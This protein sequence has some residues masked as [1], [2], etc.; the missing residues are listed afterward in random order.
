MVE[1]HIS[2]LI[3][4]RPYYWP[5]EPPFYSPVLPNELTNSDLM[6]DVVVSHS[7]PPFCEPIGKIG[8]ESWLARDNALWYDIQC[9]RNTLEQIY[10]HLLDKKNPLKQWVYGH[11]HMHYETVLDEV[12]YTALNIM[13]FKEII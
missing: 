7:D 1:F 11:F 10:R 13:E 5:D 12:H 9:E 6:I 2:C 3:E 4:G 8:I